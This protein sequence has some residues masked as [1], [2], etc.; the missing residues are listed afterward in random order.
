M[1]HPEN[2]LDAVEELCA[3]VISENVEA[4]VARI[5]LR[6]APSAAVSRAI[7]SGE[8][9]EILAERLPRLAIPVFPETICDLTHPAFDLEVI[10]EDEGFL[11]EFLRLCRISSKDPNPIEDL[12]RELH[13]ELSKRVHRSCIAPEADPLLLLENKN[14][15]HDLVTNAAEQVTSTFFELSALNLENQE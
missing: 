7:K 15:L 6:G 5:T 3:A 12:I 11:P 13:L 14:F 4:M 1:L 9:Y 8:I 2:V 10:I